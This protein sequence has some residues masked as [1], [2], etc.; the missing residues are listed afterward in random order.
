MV[1]ETQGHA[2]AI[3]KWLVLAATQ[4]TIITAFLAT[5]L[6]LAIAP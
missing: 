2:Y 5:A 3:A 6:Q 1:V 4:G